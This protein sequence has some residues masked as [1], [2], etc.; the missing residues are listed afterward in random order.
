MGKDNTMPDREPLELIKVCGPTEAEMIA[1]MLRNN[2][3]ECTLQGESS[4]NTLPATG[5][6]DEVRIWVEPEDAE[7]ASS[8]VEAFFTPVTR[9]E[10]KDAES[11]LGTDD[12]D[13][14]SG[15]TV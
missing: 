14:E 11:E 8:L 9:D 1:E 13:D 15:F 6:L 5:D 2:G 12:P 4:A 7:Q 3:I 10:L